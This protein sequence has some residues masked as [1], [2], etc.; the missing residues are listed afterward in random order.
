MTLRPDGRQL[1]FSA[2][3]RIYTVDVPGG[4]P[5]AIN[6]Q[7]EGQFQP[8]YSPDGKWIAYASWSEVTG[9]H[10]WRV[11]AT[12]GASRRLTGIAGYY[13]TP[14]W[15]PDGKSIAFIGSGD[16]HAARPGHQSAGAHQGSLMLM[17]SDGGA[18]K[19]LP[20]LAQMGHP[21]SFS[22]DGTRIRYAPSGTKES[23]LT[24]LEVYS[25]SIS[26]DDVRNE[27]LGK[28]MRYQ[29]TAR[30]IPSPDGQM[31]AIIK[32]GN[33]YLMQCPIP[34]G[35]DKFSQSLCSERRITRNGANDAGW[36]H[37]SS[38]LEW[39]FAN[40]HYSAS[41]ADLITDKAVHS[42]QSVG[43]S[44]GAI[45]VE[46]IAVDLRVAR[47]HATG[48][49]LLVGARIV[50]MRGNE[51]I[52]EGAILIENGRISRVGSASEIVAPAGVQVLDVNGK[53]IL[54]GFIDTH[55]HLDA[56][57]RDL[58]DGNHSDGL[59]HLAFG[60]T[61][62]KDPS[63]GGEHGY[64]SAELIEAG[65]MVGPRLYGTEAWTN[66]NQHVESLNDA[67]AMAERTKKLGGTFLKYHSGWNAEQRRWIAEA[68]RAN[69]LNF[70]AHPPASNLSDRLNLTTIS[71]GATSGEHEFRFSREHGDVVHFLAQSG[72]WLNVA[73]AA[74]QGRY[75]RRFWN[76][77]ESDPRIIS[78]YKGATPLKAPWNKIDEDKHGLPPL[79][80]G[81]ENVVRTAADIVREGGNY[82]VGS[83][84]DQKGIGF[85]WEMWA[86]V[87][88]GMP[89]HD[90]LRAATINGAY[91]LGM[92]KDLGS[93]E[94]GKVADLLIFDKSPLEDIRNTLTLSRVMQRGVLRDS[95]TLDEIWPVRQKLP[96]WKMS[97]AETQ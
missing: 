41:T 91:S 95:A 66:G 94:V 5:R 49:I 6:V 36:R 76:Q 75:Y 70:A 60:I 17:S 63:N 34:I 38:Q 16:L 77:V 83:H 59:V 81:P 64:A 35:S 23:R 45:P 67:I 9:G 14:V 84:G 53:T 2:L 48:S 96:E 15:S 40:H 13:Q 56:L 68:A 29:Y 80:D 86:Y 74:S 42:N 12:G 69:G 88:G 27:G 21:P 65:V 7:T 18:V 1:A 93:I 20:V 43:A 87:R 47:V 44:G 19:E 54:P 4:E 46:E 11:S 22:S 82:T 26:G 37:G 71:N 58:L 24:Q 51:M 8:S 72:A 50:T 89:V 32:H 73:S 90:V 3:R 39:S 92:Q 10:I 61:T 33:L 97:E 28:R 25:V 57:P 62:A 85:H 79:L 31:I 78:F 55:A 30:A 52:R